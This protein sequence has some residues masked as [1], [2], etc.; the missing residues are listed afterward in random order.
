MKRARFFLQELSSAVSRKIVSF[1]GGTLMTG[2]VYVLEGEEETYLGQNL[3]VDTFRLG[4]AGLIARPAAPSGAVFVQ[5]S[6]Y[7]DSEPGIFPT[8]LVL[9]HG[10]SAAHTTDTEL[11]APFRQDGVI[12]TYPLKEILFR[13]TKAQHGVDPIQVAFFFDLPEGELF[14]DPTEEDP[15]DPQL[16]KV[17][18]LEIQ[19]WGLRGSTGELLARRNAQF[20][21]PS[22]LAL[23]VRWEIR[24]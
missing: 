24:T 11:E 20:L 15:E 22:N 17:S 21:R 8:E 6:G 10:A 4:V 1:M 5:D 13:R 19:E 7:D 12:V 18:V 9:G 16:P 2:H 14:D 23:K 3:V